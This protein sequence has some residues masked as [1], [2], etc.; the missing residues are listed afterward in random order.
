MS[1]VGC[2]EDYYRNPVEH[3]D[4]LVEAI[5]N[6]NFKSYSQDVEH[7]AALK[8]F[9]RRSEGAS[10]VKS[11]GSTLTSSIYYQFGPHFGFW[12]AKIERILRGYDI[13]VSLMNDTHA[14]ASCEYLHPVVIEQPLDRYCI[15]LDLG[16]EDNRNQLRTILAQICNAHNKKISLCA[17]PNTWLHA[18]TDHAVFNDL[19]SYKPFI[20]SL[21]NEDWEAW[22]SRQLINTFHF[23]DQMIDWKSGINFYTCTSNTRHFLPIFHITGTSSSNLLNL[24]MDVDLVSDHWEITDF[25]VQM[26]PCGRPFLPTVFRSKQ[27]HQVSVPRSLIEN[28]KAGYSNL[29]FVSH[30]NTLHAL[31]STTTGDPDIDLLLNYS[32]EKDI[33]RD[34]QYYV[35]RK[36]YNF[37]TEPRENLDLTEYIYPRKEF[38]KLI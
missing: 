26:C 1:L 10:I 22:V 19:F 21:V 30:N 37:W 16:S 17:K 9:Y 25:T 32:R 15:Y 27:D 12:R 6:Y 14:T 13:L 34:R 31:Y 20:K 36:K 35:G 33:L 23:N 28:L 2:F 38:L 5:V 3:P 7:I 18:S 29:Q 4:Q 24:A 11:N 8:Q